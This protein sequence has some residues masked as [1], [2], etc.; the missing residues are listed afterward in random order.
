MV[1]NGE[2]TAKNCTRAAQNPGPTS[3]AASRAV[4]QGKLYSFP[5]SAILLHIVILKTISVQVEVAREGVKLCIYQS[6]HC[7]SSKVSV[8]NDSDNDSQ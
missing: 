5:L 2:S 8:K 4:Q 1:S 6:D 7:H 3:N